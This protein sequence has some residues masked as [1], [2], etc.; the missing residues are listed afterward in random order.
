MALDSKQKFDLKKFIKQMRKYKGR[1]TELIT[2]YVPTGYDLNS[3]I[4]QLQ[5]EV[6]TATNIK[7][8]STRNNVISALEKM[9][10]LLKTIGRNPPNGLAAFA[11]NVSEREG[12]QD[13]QS[14]HLETPLPLKTKIYRCDKEFV[15]EPLDDMVQDREIYGLV[16]LDQRDATVALLKGKAII[17]LKTTHSEVPGKMKAGGQ[18]AARFAS[19]RDL[20]I[21]G[22]YKKIAEIMKNEFLTMPDLKGII[23]GGPSTSVRNFLNKEYVTGDVQKKIIGTK[24]LSYTGEFGLQ[25][26]LELSTDI[27]AEEEVAKEKIAITNFFKHIATDSGK[28]AYGYDDVKR[29]LEMG[30]VEL[31]I[32]SD[33]LDEDKIDELEKMAEAQGT[34]ILIASTDTREGEQLSRIGKVAAILRYSVNHS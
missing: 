30:A 28:A 10:Q 23:I 5:Q 21:G 18:S 25:E 20:A 27:L 19:N 2:V 32:V 31:L 4:N 11:G 34:A 29:I 24:D 6:G 1:H 22:H 3:V 13:F 7:S 14:F 17:P 26:L 9:I 12:G 8:A 15:M 33:T 16:V